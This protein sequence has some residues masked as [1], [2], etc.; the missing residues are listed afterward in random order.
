MDKE[1]KLG[2]TT[3]SGYKLIREIKSLDEFWN[4]INT[5]KSIYARHRMYPTAFFYNWSIRL[6]KIWMIR[7]WFFQT[8]YE[9]NKIADCLRRSGKSTVHLNLLISGAI[10]DNLS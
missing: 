10:E 3:D 1:L 8:K 4:I 7:G 5:E 9:K 2:D 6:I